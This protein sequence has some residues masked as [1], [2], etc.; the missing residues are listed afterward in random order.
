M[1]LIVGGAGYIGSHMNKYL[2]N[3][4]YTTVVLDNLSK[5]HKKF[6]KWGKFYKGDFGNEKLLDK[7][8][9]QNKITAVMHFAAL[10]EV[11]ESVKNPEDYYINNVVKTITLLSKMKQHNVKTIVFSSTCSTYGEEAKSPISEDQKQ[12][13]INPYAKTKLAI[14]FALKDYSDAYGIN[15]VTLRYFNAAGADPEA[16][17]GEMHIP[18]SHLIPLVLDAAAGKRKNIKIFGTNYKTKDGTC[19]RD[20]IHVYDLAEAHLAALNY[21]EKNGGFHFFNL[22]TGKGTS[23][24]EVIESVKRVTG[25]DFDVIETERRPGDPSKLYAN[26]KK[27]KK[28]LNWEPKYTNIDDIIKTAWNWHKK[29]S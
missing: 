29:I 15:A 17:I 13:P 4:G 25:K 6:V 12:I 8:F 21:I 28:I 1:I 24:K 27:A 23:V 22:G 20:Y 2:N 3:K 14:E 19:I 18:E 10:A 5:G 16:E 7:V 26:N 9:S 11:G